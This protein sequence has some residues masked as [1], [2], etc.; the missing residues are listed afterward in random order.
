MKKLIAI[1]LAMLLPV[2]MMACGGSTDTESPAPTTEPVEA[3]NTTPGDTEAKEKVE[4]YSFTLGDIKLVPGADFDPTVLPEATSVYE[5]PSCAIEGTDNLYA[6]DSIEI[7]A[8]DDGEGEIIYSVY[9]VDA[10]TPTDEGL[11]IGDG[12]EEV[13]AIYG[14]DRTENGNELTYQK[15]DSLLIIIIENDVVISVEYRAVME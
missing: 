10:N 7:T 1:L 4:G 9:I 2:M 13:N 15:G 11:Y 5:V 8:F 6:Y 3:E 12:L 14:T